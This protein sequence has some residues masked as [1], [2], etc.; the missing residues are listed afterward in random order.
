VETFRVRFEQGCAVRINGR[1][2][3]P[4][5]AMQTANRI[6][7]RNGVG[8]KNAL[9]NRIIGTKS[10]GVYEAPGMELLG[11]CLLQVYQATMDRRATELFQ[12]LSKLVARQ[13]YDGRL[14]DPVT[15][16]AMA[17]IDVFAASATGTVTVGLYKG[18][19]QFHS[20]KDCP[21]S[22]YNPADSSM[23]ASRG[24]NPRSSQ[25][26]AEVQ[27]VEARALARAGQIR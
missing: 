18:S 10:R 2:V 1:K 11:Y 5:A 26:Y 25:G 12:Q 21:A 24:L 9:E 27:S 7:G 23:E 14:Y 3:S 6:G 16:A 13:I 22:L 19:I 15:R 4:L 20:L 17:A 8:I